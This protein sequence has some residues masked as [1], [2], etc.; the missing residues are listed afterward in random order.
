MS[1]VEVR[2]ERVQRGREIIAR[3]R[4]LE[5]ED[6]ARYEAFAATIKS[7]NKKFIHRRDPAAKM[8]AT[9]INAPYSSELLRRSNCP[10]VVISRIA[11]Y[12]E[13]DL[14]ELAEG[15]LNSAPLRR[16]TPD[17]RRRKPARRQSVDSATFPSERL[18]SQL[19]DNLTGQDGGQGCPRATPGPRSHLGALDSSNARHHQ[20]AQA[21]KQGEG[22]GTA[23][24]S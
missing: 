3:V 4:E 11:Y 12:A 2:D 21:R 7:R 10:F 20:Q 1:D 17:R 15:I 22:R 16:G 6:K 13:D 9:A 23:A 5:A 19:D 14:R 8:V 18:G 24:N